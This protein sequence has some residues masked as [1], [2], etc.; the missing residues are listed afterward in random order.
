MTSSSN[1][2]RRQAHFN[3]ANSSCC[4]VFLKNRYNN[5][6][7]SVNKTTMANLF[8]LQHYQ[9]LEISGVDTATFL[10]GQLT[11]DVKRIDDEHSSLGAYCN[12][13]GRMVSLFRLYQV[14]DAFYL[15]MPKEL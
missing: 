13:Q 7:S 1:M 2:P 5:N 11:C 9:C 8:P 15:L 12:L 6:K 14:R 10:Q 3:R 4:I